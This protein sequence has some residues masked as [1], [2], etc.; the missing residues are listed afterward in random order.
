MP[1]RENIYNFWSCVAMLKKTQYY[2]VI[3]ISSGLKVRKWEGRKTE[4]VYLILLHVFKII[5]HPWM[6]ITNVCLPK[7]FN[8]FIKIN[9]NEMGLKTFILPPVKQ[10]HEIIICKREQEN[11]IWIFSVTWSD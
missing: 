2:Y 3:V 6:N 8:N 7:Y 5:M 9:I 11:T 1:Q 4:T 10:I